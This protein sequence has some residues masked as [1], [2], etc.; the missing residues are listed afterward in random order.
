MEKSIFNRTFT[1][2]LVSYILCLILP[3]AAFSLLYATSFLSAYNNQLITKTSQNIKNVF[4]NI[5]L[6]MNSLGEI[7]SGILMN[8]RF[9]NSYLDD[10]SRLTAINSM[11]EILNNYTILSEFIHDVWI[12][13][14][15]DKY[16]FNSNNI[17][18]LDSFIRFG[19]SY[20]D[21]ST[22]DFMNIIESTTSDIWIQ[23]AQVNIFGQFHSL[24][25]YIIVYPYSPTHSDTSV[26]IF[27]NKELLDTTMRMVIPYDKSTAVILDR[28]GNIIYSFD[29]SVTSIIENIL[30]TGRTNDGTS[31]IK[32][33]DGKF[34]VHKINSPQNQLSYISL[35]PYRLLTGEVQRYTQLFIFILL[36]LLLCGSFLIFFLMRVNYKPIKN[37]VQHFTTYNQDEKNTINE[38]DLIRKTLENI[39]EEN[40]H[41]SITNKKYFKEGLLFDLLKSKSVSRDALENIGIDPNSEQYCVVIFSLDPTA[42]RT[43][44]SA[45]KSNYFKDFE[46][47]INGSCAAFQLKIHLLEYLEKNSYIGIVIC[48][49]EMQSFHETLE[50]MCLELEK[51]T[52]SEI[53]AV[54]GNMVRKI[55]DI[56]VS[57]SQAKTTLRYQSKKQNKKVLEYQKMNVNVIPDYIFIHAEMNT[58]EESIRT[59]NSR[60]TA[61]IISELIETIKNENTSYF[62]AVCLCYNIINIFFMEIHRIKSSEAMEIFKKHQMLFL[63]NFDQP[64]ENLITI[65]LS[66]SLEIM[67]V[68]GKE[69]SGHQIASKENILKFID[70][71][72]KEKNFCIQTIMDNFGMTHSNLSHQFKTYTDVNLSSYLSTLRINYAKEQLCT[73]NLT[74]REIADKLGYFQTSSFILKFKTKE[75]MTP[76]EYR[77]KHTGTSP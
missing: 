45:N 24:L 51:R 39:N 64:V 57:Y 36:G 16:F 37:I 33:H 23:Q 4:Q 8:N 17:V 21:I 3:V 42:V 22:S 1:K 71:N 61:F 50:T 12:F 77:K 46:N 56:P 75:G 62:Y 49:L 9:S 10:S 66:M 44:R 35:I 70:E 5:D 40:K 29:P 34:F 69:Q 13:N 7:R 59:G 19:F 58:L 72:F 55:K 52:R 73:T 47:I 28:E 38:I 2:Y 48:P 14:R 76:G 65:I 18:S 68:L 63:E 25:T 31:I 15:D 11:R 27:L 6:R 30:G 74:V 41:L 43:S 54:C 53:Y 20:P 67:R 26:I 60:Q 32:T